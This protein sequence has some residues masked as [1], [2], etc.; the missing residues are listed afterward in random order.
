MPE[1]STANMKDAQKVAESA[2]A[3]IHSRDHTARALGITVEAIGLGYARLTMS[4][5]QD[6]VNG[7][8]ILHG[9]LCF[10]LADTCFAHACNSSNINT[11]AHSCTITYTAPGHLG[12]ELVAEG[13]EIW[14]E[15]RNGVADVTVSRRCDGAVIAL[16]RGNARRIGG[17]VIDAYSPQDKV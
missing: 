9:G 11:L 6:M 13:R 4:V 8:N 3:A 2:S 17:S 15:G 7:H 5:R 12:D 10:T 14:Q 16:F 1:T